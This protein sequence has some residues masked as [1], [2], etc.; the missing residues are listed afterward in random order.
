MTDLAQAHAVLKS[1]FEPLGVELGA[2]VLALWR[3]REQSGQDPLP[4]EALRRVAEIASRLAQQ[5]P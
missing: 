5:R 1:A 4:A 3:D 2:D